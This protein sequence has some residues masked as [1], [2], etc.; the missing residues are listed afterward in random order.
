MPADP[1]GDN[2]FITFFI[3]SVV[4]FILGILY[5]VSDA[6]LRHGSIEKQDDEKENTKKEQIEKI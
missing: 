2:I 5:S 4:F 6:A 3:I 1:D